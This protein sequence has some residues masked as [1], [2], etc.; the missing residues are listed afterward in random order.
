MPPS[1]ESVVGLSAFSLIIWFFWFDSAIANDKIYHE[2]CHNCFANGNQRIREDLGRAMML[3][4]LYFGIVIGTVVIEPQYRLKQSTANEYRGKLL[5]SHALI[6]A[7]TAL[8]VHVPLLISM[9]GFASSDWTVL[10]SA[11]TFL[12]VGFLMGYLPSIYQR[13]KCDFDGDVES[14][15]TPDGVKY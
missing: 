3:V 13:L 2:T 9:I 15:T 10:I 12:A 14:W 11:F 1:A 5:S 4:F 6:K 8:L 7:V